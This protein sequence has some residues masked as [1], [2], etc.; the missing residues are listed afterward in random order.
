MKKKDGFG[1]E[2]PHEGNT[3]DWITPEWV[4][5]GFNNLAKDRGYF[6]DLD[7]CISLT[8]P[9]LTAR[10]AYSIEQD[11]LKQT[12]FG[13]VYCNSPYGENVGIWA[14]RMAEHNNGIMLIFART[15]T[16]TWQDI[17]FPSASGYLFLDG[18]IVFHLPDGSLP[19]NNKGQI[20]SA[21]APSVF[22]AWG[23]DARNALKKISTKGMLD[24]FGVIRKGKFLK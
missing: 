10:K 21:G 1:H 19:R 5:D 9:W 17:I 20:A 7:P 11:G 23:K 12:W 6:F 15:E 16:R 18:R 22:V 2:K 8:Q 13:M 24:E 3:N 4:I 14:K